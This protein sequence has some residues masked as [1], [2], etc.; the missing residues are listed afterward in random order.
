M[1]ADEIR[2]E[3][4]LLEFVGRLST[5]FG[6][7]HLGF[8]FQGERMYIGAIAAAGAVANQLQLRG[9]RTIGLL[10]AQGYKGVATLLG[11]SIH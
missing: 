11:K 1:G 10:D 7:D 8:G 9:K 5:G 3:T 2:D 6:A 4:L